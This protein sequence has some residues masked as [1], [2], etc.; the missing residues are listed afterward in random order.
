MNELLKIST[1]EGLE[2]MQNVINQFKDK[3]PVKS[4]DM[5]NKGLEYIDK[6]KGVEVLLRIE[7]QRVLSELMDSEN[8]RGKDERLYS[9]QQAAEQLGCHRSTLYNVHLKNGLK[10]V[11]FGNRN[12]KIKASDLY[13]YIRSLKSS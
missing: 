5:I 9:M 8:N 12:Q 7:Q 2:D 4:L 1:P 3:S 10:S 13:D 6:L 11:N